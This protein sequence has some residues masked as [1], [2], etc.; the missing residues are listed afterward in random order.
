MPDCKRTTLLCTRADPTDNLMPG[1]TQRPCSLCGTPSNVSP[2]SQ[3]FLESH[4]E[5]QI[6]CMTCAP[7]EIAATE[8]I[9]YEV[10]DET[11]AAVSALWGRRVTREELSA[12]ILKHLPHLGF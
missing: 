2:A 8:S 10:T 3:H 7:K 1:F 11:L 5:T 6:L 4:P 9:Q 12:L